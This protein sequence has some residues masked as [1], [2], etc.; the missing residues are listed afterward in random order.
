MVVWSKQFMENKRLSVLI[1]AYSDHP[2]TVAHVRE[3][4]NSIRVPDEII[5]VNDHGDPSLREML[6]QLPKK[7]PV[8]YAY[9]IDDIPW[10]YTGARNLAFFISRGDYIAIEDNDHIPRANWYEEALKVFVERPWVDR[11]YGEDRWKVSRDEVGK[12]IGEWQRQGKRPYHRDTCVMKRENYLLVKGY[13]ER[14]AGAYAWACT[15]W[16]RRNERAGTKYEFANSNYWVV[17]DG[18]RE[19]GVKNLIRRRSYRNYGFA[20]EKDGHIQSPK[21]IINFTYTIENL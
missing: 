19:G 5:V 9:I 18:E 20:R 4:M 10:N 12:P 21:G 15:D 3:C 7:C 17:I 8:I 13:D 1:S 16:R 14:F 11:V 2:V 6:I